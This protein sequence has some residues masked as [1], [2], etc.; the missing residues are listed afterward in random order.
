MGANLLLIFLFILTLIVCAIFIKKIVKSLIA[1]NQKFYIWGIARKIT[2]E[3][4]SQ[5]EKIW[6]EYVQVISTEEK[7]WSSGNDEN[8]EEMIRA[9]R[10]TLKIAIKIAERNEPISNLRSI[11]DQTS[12]IIGK[13]TR[14]IRGEMFG[15]DALWTN[16]DTTYQFPDPNALEKILEGFTERS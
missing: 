16:E 15:S 9:K 11:L 7:S 12:K 10:I 14:C 2:R 3:I 5:A 1:G 13:S 4:E 8:C 6:A